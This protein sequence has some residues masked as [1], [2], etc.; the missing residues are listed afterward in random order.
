MLT[1]ILVYILERTVA[2]VDFVVEPMLLNPISSI[3][4]LQASMLLCISNGSMILF[5]KIWNCALFMVDCQRKV[6]RC[7]A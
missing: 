5:D 3:A 4:N 1:T 6:I 2:N 7:R